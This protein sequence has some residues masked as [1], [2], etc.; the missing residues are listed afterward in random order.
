[1]TLSPK[2]IRQQ[3]SRS[4]RARKGIPN[5][6]QVLRAVGYAAA[7]AS[8]EVVIQTAVEMLTNKGF[9]EAKTR[10]EVPAFI[11][12]RQDHDTPTQRNTI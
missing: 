1:M 2:T 5:A 10:K 3:K 11:A 7:L 8:D 9:D 6:G 4:E 12:R